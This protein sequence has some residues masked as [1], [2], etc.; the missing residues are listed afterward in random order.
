LQKAAQDV[1]MDTML[2]YFS[3]GEET[4]NSRLRVTKCQ[5]ILRAR[6]RLCAQMVLDLVSRREN[7]VQRS[8]AAAA[9]GVSR[10]ANSDRSLDYIMI[11]RRAD[12]GNI[13]F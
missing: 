12:C 11:G 7:V 1:G 3:A 6:W 9:G 10:L 2:V 4:N 5:N 8:T 13:V